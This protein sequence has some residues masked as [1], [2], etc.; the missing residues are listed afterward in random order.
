MWGYVYAYNYIYIDIL[1]DNIINERVGESICMS[2]VTR[3]LIDME[4]NL[5]L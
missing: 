2:N 1:L 5:Y 4:K 3:K